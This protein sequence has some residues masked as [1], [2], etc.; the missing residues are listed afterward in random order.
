MVAG[1]GWVGV[2]GGVGCGLVG[3]WGL[4]VDHSGDFVGG[5]GS[6]PRG[7]VSA[8]RRWKKRRRGGAVVRWST[9]HA[10]VK[11][12]QIS[13]DDSEDLVCVLLQKVRDDVTRVVDAGAR[14][15][16]QGR[17]EG[18]GEGQVE[19]GAAAVGFG[20]RGLGGGA[21]GRDMGTSTVWRTGG[22]DGRQSRVKRGHSYTVPPATRLRAKD[23]EEGS[24]DDTRSLL[25]K[26]LHGFGLVLA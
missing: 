22:G 17:V 10:L 8:R 3:G 12:S 26:L 23:L 7:G 11:R 13:P 18:G 1:F 9:P 25:H 20:R 6:A 14:G 19:G 21:C 16:L 2:T 24:A 15:G 4:K 5:S